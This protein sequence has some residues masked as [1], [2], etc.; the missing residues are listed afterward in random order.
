M[1]SHNTKADKVVTNEVV[2]IDAG[3]EGVRVLQLDL[4]EASDL[5]I[6]NDFNTGSDPYNSTGQHVIIKSRINL[7][8]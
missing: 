5:A 4:V 3:L 8:D 1:D 2:S 7:E 6:A